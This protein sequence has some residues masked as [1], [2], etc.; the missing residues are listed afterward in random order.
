MQVA[1]HRVRG[2]TAILEKKILKPIL[3]PTT[4][5]PATRPKSHSPAFTAATIAK[6]VSFT[7]EKFRIFLFH[8]NAM[9]DL[10][11]GQLALKIRNL[12]L[13]RNGFFGIRIF[14][15]QFTA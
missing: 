9:L 2:H 15:S 14:F 4:A 13:K 5:T 11:L 8:F 6:A 3:V 1:P 7:G 10:L 12:F